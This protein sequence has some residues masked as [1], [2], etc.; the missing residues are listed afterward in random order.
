MLLLRS[1]K[2]ING[3][4]FTTDCKELQGAEFKARATTFNTEESR[5]TEGERERDSKRKR[6]EKAL[7]K[8]WSF[9]VSLEVRLPN[10]SRIL[11]WGTQ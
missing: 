11:A 8:D 6:G 4:V 2:L 9:L 1:A 5:K 7:F 10:C 3:T